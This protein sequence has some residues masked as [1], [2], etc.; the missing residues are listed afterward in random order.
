MVT[1]GLPSP[2]SSRSFQVCCLFLCSWSLFTYLITVILGTLSVLGPL[3]VTDPPCL[4]H[5]GHSRSLSVLGHSWIPLTYLMVILG[6]LSVL[7]PL[8]LMKPPYLPHHGHSRYSVHSVLDNSWTPL[9]YLITEVTLCGWRG[10]KPSINKLHH[11]YSRY[12]V[13]SW[14]TGTHRLPSSTSWSC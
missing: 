10:N 1:R 2:T 14:S 6:T 13:C 5:R 4:P 7:G 3:V 9:T 12:V 11:V 8:V